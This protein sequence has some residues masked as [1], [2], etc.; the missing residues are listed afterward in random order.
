M[1]YSLT[2]S[3]AEV[4]ASARARPLTKELFLIISMHMMNRELSQAFSDI[5]TSQVSV[6]MRFRCGETF[7]YCF[8]TNLL[9]SMCRR[10]NFENRSAFCKV[11]GRGHDVSV[12]WITSVG[13]PTLR[14][15]RPWI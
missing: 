5:N 9:L 1:H 12:Y 7:N 13:Q 8:T 4:R 10:K 14:Q 15:R 11:R 2:G 6:A 3:V